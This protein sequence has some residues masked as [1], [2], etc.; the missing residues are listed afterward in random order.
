MPRAQDAQERRCS[1][2]GEA[3]NL[4]RGCPGVQG[5]TRN[6]SR[7]CPGVRTVCRGRRQGL[8]PTISCISSVP[9]GQ[10]RTTAGMQEQLP[11]SGPYR[12]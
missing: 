9:G 2:Q 4:P 7:E 8:F 6:W 3:G 1:G 12:I 10:M 11:R 5:E